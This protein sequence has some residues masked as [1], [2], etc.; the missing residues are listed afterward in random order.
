VRTLGVRD[1]VYRQAIRARQ[2]VPIGWRVVRS[3][4]AALMERARASFAGVGKDARRR[5]IPI[6]MRVF[7]SAGAPL[8]LVA[9]AAD[10][11]VTL[12]SESPL[13]AARAQ[14]IDS[15][16][17]RE[18]LGRLG[19]S[20]FV[21]AELDAHG[22]GDGLFLP[23]RELNH[24]RQRAVEELTV[25]CDWVREAERAERVARIRS[26]IEQ[27]GAAP[28][29]ASGRPR[30]VAEVWP[31]ADA[32]AA[33][34]AGADEVVLDPFLR[35]PFPPV[36]SVGAL[37]ERASARGVAVRLRLPTIVRPSERARLDKWLA[38]GT[39]LLTGHLGLLA[40]LAAAGR[41]VA[42]DYAANCFNAHTA[43]AL[44]DLGASRVTPSVELTVDELSSLVAPWRGVGFEAFVFGRPEGMTLEHCVLSAAFD[45]TPT[46]CRDLCTKTHPDTRLTDP[47][48]YVFPV[49]TDYACR[50]RLLH[51]RPVDGTEFLP[52]LVAAGFGVFRTVFNVPGD[53]VARTVSAYRHS[54]DS[55]A[56]GRP[57]GRGAR[58]VVPD[59]FTRGHFAR[60]V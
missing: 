38:L 25:R 28:G 15:G 51:S 10:H 49:A 44:F 6:T 21:L 27:V 57:P 33:I 8:K 20:P 35:H 55:V 31:V 42:A 43:A 19:E 37:I 59:G 60:A 39:P 3:S 22:L 24:L 5:R 46:H 54:L 56:A 1:G 16:R 12:R 9:S 4:Q 17:L 30:L 50:N 58:D 32:D 13:S 26:A 45:R 53:D 41:D 11:E 2:R 14:A 29:D 36:T 52:R 34:A 7:G 47:A 40:E 23:V 18:Q 48:G